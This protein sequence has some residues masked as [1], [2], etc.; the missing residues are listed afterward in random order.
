VVSPHHVTA[1]ED[2]LLDVLVRVICAFGVSVS[3]ASAAAA[4]V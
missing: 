4:V 2:A 3:A 1:S